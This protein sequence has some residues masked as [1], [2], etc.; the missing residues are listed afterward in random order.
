MSN[1]LRSSE[2]SHPGA[3]WDDGR[4]VPG[5]RQAITVRGCH[6]SREVSVRGSL[7]IT[8]AAKLKTAVLDGIL[9]HCRR[10]DLDLSRVT[11]LD[12]TGLGVLARASKLCRLEGVDLRLVRPSAAVRRVLDMTLLTS[13]FNIVACLSLQHCP[14]MKRSEHE[15]TTARSDR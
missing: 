8:N 2:W 11:F 9:R 15:A 3:S 7:D 5:P 6:G 13:S 14:T 12:S 1:S 4:P 10:L